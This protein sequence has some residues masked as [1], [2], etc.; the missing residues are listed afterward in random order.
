MTN[1]RARILGLMLF[2]ISTCLAAS[3]PQQ[4]NKPHSSQF[5]ASAFR[6]EIPLL[7]RLPQ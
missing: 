7:R 4:E 1:G 6:G 3:V 5:T 2:G